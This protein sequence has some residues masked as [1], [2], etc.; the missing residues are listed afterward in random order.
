M[1]VA[2][3]APL[4]AP[5]HPTPSG[6][7]QMAQALCRLLGELG[8]APQL[9]SRLRSYDRAG[10]ALRQRRLAR[11]GQAIA[12]RFVRAVRQGRQPRPT[13]WVTY[14][15]YHKAPDHLGPAVG[16]ALDLPYL[17]IESSIASKQ[18]NGAWAHGH[19]VS[20]Q[21][22]AR[23]DAVLALTER[24]VVGLRAAVGGG[25]LGLLRPFIDVAA[26]AGHDRAAAREGWA[27]RLGLPPGEPWLLAVAM[28][29]D[30]VKRRSY[31]LLGQALARLL[32]RPWRL[33][34][35]GDGTAREAVLAG[36]VAKLGGGRV[37]FAGALP[38]PALAELYTATDLLVWPALD[39]AYGLVL[40][41]AQ[42]AGLPV[43][44]GGAG[45]VPEIVVD[46]R[47]GLLAEAGNPEALSAATA[48]LLA[49]PARR[50]AMGAAGAVHVKARHD[51][52]TARA[53]LA[54]ALAAAA[55]HHAGRR[56][57]A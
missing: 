31:D 28:M 39:E 48:T 46:G 4:K 13:A 55:L 10:D 8:E 52:P 57:A 50:R 47:T 15:G 5:D 20:L 42:A 17:S 43:V 25:R 2:F 21:A 37:H 29:R 41:E 49:D 12:A 54:A 33:A 11:L 16:D 23:A 44:A 53:T 30:D 22:L 51:L 32:D 36:L 6:D 3:Y 7:R 38:Q 14:H 1:S 26:F 27:G 34:V 24:D 45:G 40:L 35:A 56:A 18:A 9:A 19:A